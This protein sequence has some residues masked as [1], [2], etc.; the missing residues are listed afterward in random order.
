MEC[1]SDKPALEVLQEWLDAFINFERLP[2]KDIFWLDTMEFLCHR[3]GQPEAAF[4]S[5]HVAG[6]KGK[7][8]VCAMIASIIAAGGEGSGIYASPHISSFA[9]RV[10]CAD[11]FLPEDVYAY[12]VDELIRGVDSILPEQL[13]GEREITWFELVTLYAFLCFRRAG[14]NWA[15][16]E[17][18]MGGRLD[19]TNVLR[20]RV[21]VLT[22]IEL[23]HTE[24][25]GSTLEKIAGEKAGI[26]KEGGIVC[27]A[28]SQQEEVLRAIRAQAEKMS[29]SMI[30][31]DEAVS[32]LEYS[33]D[34]DG[35]SVRIESPYFSRPIRT[36]LRLHG[37]FQAENAALAAIAAK[38]AIDSLSEDAIEA[39]L[40]RAFI[41]G[42][43]EILRN[44]RAGCV[45]V[46]DGAHTVNSVRGSILALDAVF[47]S[48]THRRHLLFACAADKDMEHIAPLCA[49]FERI[50]LT[51]PGEKKR[52]SLSEL[53]DSFERAGL[54]YRVESDYARAITTAAEEA[55]REG[56]VLLVAG[57][58]YLVAEARALLYPS[59]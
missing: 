16:I 54:E 19:A 13:P 15:V 11:G 1:M 38:T 48:G 50:T 30:F 5:V 7:G 53:C 9:E 4:N 41:P 37:G 57:S 27:I 42:R 40:A 39:G 43:F 51:V 34:E 56:A 52:S 26:I 2:K 14:L 44:T 24:Y 12:A 47:P 28:R 8:S 45:L 23:E 10:R 17:T 59:A 6:S 21:S 18:G 22:P 25:L 49:H 35:T 3:F 36:K 20:P 31:A 29:A 33:V 58:F 32:S 55:A 46:F